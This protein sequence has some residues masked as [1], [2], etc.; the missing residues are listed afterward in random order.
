MNP[1]F[2]RNLWLEISPMRLVLMP[3]LIGLALAAFASLKPDETA[4][5]ALTLSLLGFFAITIVWGCVQAQNALSRE[6]TEGTWDGQRMSALTPWQM[7]WGKLFGSTIYTWYGGLMLLA[8][9]GF[10]ADYSPAPIEFLP[11]QIGYSPAQ[12]IFILGCGL[13]ST[14]LIVHALALARAL[15]THRKRPGS[16]LRFPILP[17]LLLLFLLYLFY[18]LSSWHFHLMGRSV[19]WWGHHWDRQ[20]LFATTLVFMAPWALIH[21]WE[22]MRRELMLPN[23]VWWWPLFLLFWLIWSAGFVRGQEEQYSP[24][25]FDGWYSFFAVWAIAVGF[26]VYILLFSARKDQGMWLRLIAACQNPNKRLLQHLEPGWLISFLIAVGLGSVAVI[27]SPDPIPRLMTLLCTVAFIVRD[28]I[29]IL[30]LNLARNARRAEGAALVSLIVAYG[31][32]PLLFR[33]GEVSLLLP[34]LPDAP[35]SV[36]LLILANALIQAA[37]CAGLFYNRWRQMFRPAEPTAYKVG[38]RGGRP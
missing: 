25:F 7:A 26:S 35:S 23:R 22:T 28:I 36:A 10:S 1:E 30:W 14:A 20:I 12:K 5:T 16:N 8:I 13:I 3:A 4:R 18:E 19:L 32:L 27:L 15:Q 24:F 11:E 17:F 6:V 33:S 21:L 37:F 31:L 38:A 9:A 34:P 29:W 2:K